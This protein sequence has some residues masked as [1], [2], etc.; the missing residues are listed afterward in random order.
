MHLIP[1]DNQ[2]LIAQSAEAFLSDVSSMQAVRRSSESGDGFDRGLWRGITELGWCGVRLPEARGGLGAGWVELALLQ[3][4][5]G[6]HLACA[7]FFDS[8]VLAGAFLEQCVA[9]AAVADRSALACGD[10]IVTCALPEPDTEI[11]ARVT[12]RGPEPILTGRWPRVGSAQFADVLLLPAMSS[13]GDTLVLRVPADAPGLMRTNLPPVDG[14]RRFADVEADGLR[15]TASNCLMRGAAARAAL[16]RT[17]YLGAI[18][19]AAE[20]VG[21]AQASFDG[22]LAYAQG[23]EQFGKPIAGFQAIKHRFAQMLVLLETARSAVYGAACMADTEPD[24]ATLLLHAA[25]AR[26]AA[27]EAAQA[28]TSEAIQ[29]H[30]GVGFTWDYDP[31]MHFRRAQGSRQRLGPVRWWRE[32]VARLLLDD[33]QESL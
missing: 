30:G 19:L 26:D 23:R 33:V 4:Q 28:C 25:Q 9:S 16:A 22:A 11:V 31:H 7:P 5:L 14:T 13:Q 3:E 24:E 10:L 21:V 17:R 29:I 8:V 15:L 2:R 12:F 18:M 27:T 6:R 20:Q 32:Q 1:T